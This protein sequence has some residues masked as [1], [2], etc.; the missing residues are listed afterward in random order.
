[1]VLRNAYAIFI[2]LKTNIP[3][4]AEVRRVATSLHNQFTKWSENDET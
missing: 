2:D 3:K 4:S 1:M